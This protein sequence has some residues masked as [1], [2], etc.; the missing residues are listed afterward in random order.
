MIPRGSAGLKK[1][2]S[3]FK[4]EGKR[5]GIRMEVPTFLRSDFHVLQNLQYEMKMA[6]RKMK[7]SIKFDEENL[8][9]VLDV[10]L[11]GQTV[12]KNLK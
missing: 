10:Q 1:K 11:P 12:F 9:L 6:N 2:A 4:L 5:A 3:G 7:R 8:G